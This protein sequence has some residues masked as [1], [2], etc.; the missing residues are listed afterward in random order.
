MSIPFRRN[1]NATKTQR[2]RNDTPRLSIFL[3]GSFRVALD[4]EPVTGFVSDKARA[5]LAFL[6][7]EAERAHRR[8]A[9]VG[10]LWPEYPEHS[11]RASLRNVLANLR[12]AIGD[13]EA[14]PSFLRIVGQTIQFNPEA[15]AQ[16]DVTAF[17]E[18]LELT[19]ASPPYDAETIHE[20]EAAVALYQGG[21]LEGFSLPDS[22]AF[23]EWA[24]LKREQLQR[25]ALAALGRLADHYERRGDYERALRF[26]WRRVE[27]D[28]YRGVAQR[29][30]MRLLAL[31]GQREAALAQYET[32]RRLLAEEMGV[33]PAEETVRLC[34]QIQA[35]ELAPMAPVPEVEVAGH[36]PAFLEEAAEREETERP[37]FIGRE[38]E[39]AR[40][41]GYLEAALAGQGQVA[42]VIGGPGQGKT[43]L[44]REFA[45]RAM[46]THPDLLVATGNC[47]AYSGVGDPYLPFREALGM[48]TGGVEASWTAGIISRDHA[49]RLWA[50]LPLALQ[51]LV[52]HGPSLIGTI[53]SDP[54]LLSR[55]TAV[56]PEGAGWLRELRTLAER[57]RP[58]HS[59]LE[60]S[61]I[62]H[63]FTNVL[64]TLA[65]THPLLLMLDDVQWADRASIGLLFHLGR[66]L[67]GSRI[68][69]ACAYRPEE[70]A[71]ERG[72]ERHPLEKVLAEFKRS[73]GD[74]WV[75][76]KR[77]DERE[78]RSFVDGFLDTE[79]NR[80]GEEFRTALFEHAGGHPLF[81]VEVLRAMQERGDLLKD[82]DG[83]W[84]KGPALDW[85]LLPARVEAV[86]EERIDRLDPE[87]QDILAVASVEGE[88]FTA[89]VVAEMLTTPE[90]AVLRRLSEDL[91]RRHRLVREQEE[92]ET[93]Q[94][95]LS[96]YR[97]G[98]ILFQ[99]Y[100]YK[101][102]SPG[103]R[104]LLHGDAAAAL[105]KLYEGQLDEMVV[106]LAHHWERAEVAEQAIEYLL[107]AGDQA[108]LV[109]ANEEA[110]DYYERALVFLKEQGEHGRT[111]RAL[112]KLGLT[113]HT[114]FDFHR[115]RRAYHEGF[116][117]WQRAGEVQV[118]APPP[119]PHALREYLPLV[120]TLDQ[121]MHM[122]DVPSTQVMQQLFSGLVEQGPELDIVPDVARHWEVSED[123]CKYIFHLRDDVRWSDGEPV[124]AGDFEYAWKR[125]LDLA[126]KPDRG[127]LLCDVKGARPFH[128]GEVSDPDRVGVQA[129][130]DVT[131]T[132][133]LEGP[134]SYF[135]HLLAQVDTCPVPRHVVE[136]HGKTWTEVNNLVTN[137]PF[138]LEAWQRG[139]SMALVRNPEY[140]GRFSGNL[141]RVELS[142][143]ADPS[144]RLKMYETDGLD[145]LNL[146]SGFPPP[147]MDRARQRHAGEYVSPPLL[148]TYYVGFD[149][150]RPP[151]D[152]P[153]VRRAFAMAI[154]KETL[155]DVVLQGYDSPA[156]GGFVPPGMP[157]HSPGIN[158]PYNPDQARRLLAEAGYPGG[159]GFP[160]VDWIAHSRAESKI[161][162]LQAQ[163]R[164][165]LGIE[166]T[167][168]T[169][170]WARYFDRLHSELPHVFISGW[171]ADY[172]DPDY[173]LRVGPLPIR[174]RWNKA[175]DRLVEE[176]RRVTD[177]R[178]RMKLY[179]QADRMLVQEAVIVP[180]TYGRAHLLVKPWVSKYP[181]SAAGP[182]LV[183]KDVII[184]PH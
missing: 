82:E 52:D 93:G 23:E 40:L 85:E 125:M 113:Y 87:L 111:A 76:L 39:L 158:L 44:M 160:V 20:M 41:A 15:D 43:A 59:G 102:L 150:S 60:Q 182:R 38:R 47:N 45:R 119:A 163:W 65:E 164:E 103:E 30:L 168:D 171:G 81:T 57:E 122:D 24:L 130:D 77:A 133:E 149:V 137:G 5:L 98:H 161:E 104:R 14:D 139:E 29:G 79:P 97:F 86:I 180:L 148:V 54:T 175:Y 36:P 120:S 69:I 108:R 56:V 75:D 31:N 35:G 49:L 178:E 118:A 72:G 155:A 134:T 109:Y 90:R 66:R 42:F 13:R 48:L 173:F 73:F 3:L 91:E 181:V 67:E 61:A 131:L 140:H 64:R 89:Q 112:M 106:Q 53:L 115:S 177:Q 142:L 84:I 167:W 6:A 127:S 135:L 157:G 176:A 17:I 71:L 7:I 27:V 78:G 63:Q 147:E 101:R 28:P 145:V 132:V 144:V 46:E 156:T 136:R 107:Q 10:L 179:G 99:E 183:W 12:Q 154:D 58:G 32:F 80:L 33:A 11:A 166:I 70:V 162:Y 151:F 143:H 74:V 62:F 16:V 146:R 124:T 152:D 51:A 88:V 116:A 9:L 96:R 68:L 100:L 141:E 34:E 126:T 95:R 2:K 55:A 153:G 4:G 50:A 169:M 105:E 1:E 114:I 21:F 165:N 174:R 22:P 184:E 37:V 128:Q 18:G 138:R 83:R 121:A 110:I 19:T 117:L 123:G 25:Q 170:E 172:P 92:V 159:R 94:R 129:V 8:E 26:A